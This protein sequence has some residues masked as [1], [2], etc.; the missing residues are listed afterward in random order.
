[1]KSLRKNPKTR[2]TYKKRGGKTFSSN[3]S[4][5]LTYSVTNTPVTCEICNSNDYTEVIGT[6]GKSKVRTGVFN[7][8]FGDGTGDVFDNTSIIM[9]TCNVCGHCRFIRNKN[10]LLI[11]TPVTAVNQ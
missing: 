1:M 5:T 10:P 2:K 3:G 11:V 9:Y 8:V 4:Q 6:I 7:A